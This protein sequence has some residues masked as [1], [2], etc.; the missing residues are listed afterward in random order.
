MEAT[1][2]FI[3]GVAASAVLAAVAIFTVA[4]RRGPDS[5]PVT[6]P[7]TGA[8]DKRAIARDLASRA[9]REEAVGHEGEGEGGVAT[10]VAEE[11]EQLEEAEAELEPAPDPILEREE[12]TEEEF[13]VTRRQFFNRAILGLFGGAFMGGLTISFLAFLWPRLSGGFGSPIT[14]GLVSDLRNQIVRADGSFSPQFVAAA[15][16]WIVPWTRREGTEGTSFEGL[17]VVAGDDG[18]ELGLMALW[19]KCVHLGC[20]VPSCESSQGFECPCHGSKYNLH[21]EYEDGPA[22]R[23]LDHFGVE[24]DDRG[25]LVV[26]TGDVFETARAKVKTVAYPQGPN[27]L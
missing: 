24:V 3:I 17:P 14:V 1:T 2:I 21:G 9:H 18:G 16:T 5:R 7:S 23:N 10:L 22:P 6:T 15:Q 12:V 25:E 26:N 4:Y 13:E 20:R 11:P 19:Q 8:L 27:C